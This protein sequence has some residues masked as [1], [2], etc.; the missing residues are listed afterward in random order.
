MEPSSQTTRPAHHTYPLDAVCLTVQMF[1]S[2]AVSF[3]GCSAVA[4]LLRQSTPLFSRVPAPNTAQSWL[5]RI[6]L[7]ELLRPK[8]RADDWVFIVDHTI[9]L[10][11]LKCLLI[12]G[13]RQS[14][15]EQLSRPLA[16][17]DLTFISLDPVEKSDG[18]KVCQQLE[19]AA[20][21]VG[22]PRAILSDHG[23]DLTRGT[24]IFRETHPETLAR[25]DIAHQVAIVLKHELLSDSR[26]GDFV[27]HCGQ[28]QPKVKQTELGNL[29][30]PMQKMKGRY[31]NLGR[32]IGWGVRMLQL[33]D[34]PEA[35]RPPDIDLTRVDDKFGWVREFRE[36]LVDWSDLEAVKECVL[37]Y[38]RITG[39]RAP[40]SE[41]LN[42][43][44]KSIAHTCCGRRMATEL[45]RF[46]KEQSQ[47]M[48]LGESLPASS[49]VLESLIGKG[50]RMQ[51][52]HSR[53][54]FTKMILGMAASVVQIT[55]AHV[56]EALES[57]RCD[58]L[59][60]WCNKHLGI[61]LTAQRRHALPAT[62][63]TKS[64]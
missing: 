11:K 20:K 52:Q 4:G 6:G 40:V 46:V 13:I 62:C 21:Q 30:P 32:L 35:N 47:D 53:G 44:L 18:E 2:G 9:Q 43:R 38:A 49:E 60:N 39:Y 29:A 5:L 12:V 48:K 50:K 16:H 23:S 7:H 28:T 54:G 8:E 34:T 45:V 61:S 22:I 3:R 25:Q 1:L 27:K 55:H 31:M 64:G 24:H 33:L 42:R 10:G 14:N 56:R 37:Q 17:Q 51:G 57:V 36:A 19:S 59:K 15:W 41:E 63:G 26:W 58:D